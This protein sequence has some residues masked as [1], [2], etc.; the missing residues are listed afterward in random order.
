MYICVRFENITSEETK[1]SIYSLGGIPNGTCLTTPV[2]STDIYEKFGN[3]VIVWYV[4]TSNSESIYTLA[5]VAKY[6]GVNSVSV[7][8]FNEPNPTYG[9]PEFDSLRDKVLAYLS[10]GD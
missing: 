6:P 3:S 7:L 5:I 9:T 8:P 2:F 1:K 10:R 4:H